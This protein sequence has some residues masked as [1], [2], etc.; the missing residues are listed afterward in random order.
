MFLNILHDRLSQVLFQAYHPLSLGGGDSWSLEA[1]YAT[2][3]RLTAPPQ[4]GAVFSPTGATT[5]G[6]DDEMFP[7]RDR[8]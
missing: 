6:T 7:F 8:G 1:H 3:A 4:K 2:T 5:A